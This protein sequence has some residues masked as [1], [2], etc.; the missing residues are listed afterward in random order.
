MDDL[1][2][3]RTR[4]NADTSTSEKDHL[5]RTR[6]GERSDSRD[7]D[8]ARSR[9]RDRSRDRDRDRGRDRGRDRHRD[10]S[11]SS[12]GSRSRSRDRRDDRRHRDRKDR[13]DDDNESKRD[14]RVSSLSSS[15]KDGGNSKDADKNKSKDKSPRKK[16]L[17]PEDY[18]S[19]ALSAAS[20]GELTVEDVAQFRYYGRYLLSFPDYLRTET[21]AKQKAILKDAARM[22]IPEK[23]FPLYAPD[24]AIY[25]QSITAPVNKFQPLVF[26]DPNT[27]PPLDPPYPYPPPAM[28]LPAPLAKALE[29]WPIPQGTALDTAD[30]VHNPALHVTEYAKAASSHDKLLQSLWKGLSDTSNDSNKIPLFVRT[31][32]NYVRYV[33][34]FRILNSKRFFEL[35]KDGEW[36]LNRYRFISSL[37]TR[38]AL[39]AISTITS[40]STEGA[41]ANEMASEGPEF[42]SS[43]KIGVQTLV[44]PHAGAALAEMQRLVV[45]GDH[46]GSGSGTEVDVSAAI[47]AAGANVPTVYVPLTSVSTDDK[48]GVQWR[49]TEVDYAREQREWASRVEACQSLLRALDDIESKGSASTQVVGDALHFLDDPMLAYWLDDIFGVQSKTATGAPVRVALAAGNV[50]VTS[51]A[52]LASRLRTVHSEAV[53]Y[54]GNW[55]VIPN[56]PTYCTKAWVASLCASAKGYLSMHLSPPDPYNEYKRTAFVRFKT[57]ALCSEYVR[58]AQGTKAPWG[59]QLALMSLSEH[60]Q[61]FSLS[62]FFARP[63][64]SPQATGSVSDP[65]PATLIGP[66]QLA[67]GPAPLRMSFSERVDRDLEA[68][69]ELAVALDRVRGLTSCFDVDSPELGLPTP[70]AKLNF[71]LDYLTRVHHYCYYSG[72]QYMNYDEILTLSGEVFTRMPFESRLARATP[73]GSVRLMLPLTTVAETTPRNTSDSMIASESH[74]DPILEWPEQ[75]A[76]A[77]IMAVEQSRLGPKAITN[78]TVPPPQPLILEFRNPVAL[79]TGA[80]A[81]SDAEAILQAAEDDF[82]KRNGAE[83]K[84]K[85]RGELRTVYQCELCK[86]PFESFDFLKAHITSKHGDELR[87]VR[88]AAYKTVYYSRYVNDPVFPTFPLSQAPPRTANA[89]RNVDVGA[90]SDEGLTTN[91]DNPFV[92]TVNAAEA[93]AKSLADT[94]ES[95][96]PKVSEGW[97]VDKDVVGDLPIPKAAADSASSPDDLLALKFSG[98]LSKVATAIASARARNALAR[99]AQTKKA[100]ISEVKSS[101]P[102]KVLPNY[103]GFL[104]RDLCSYSDMPIT[105][106]VPQLELVKLQTITGPL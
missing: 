73:P 92:A 63:E 11:R 62:L 3:K 56:I 41:G 19:V 20:I 30:A 86:K 64:S 106:D 22:G 44:H 65:L 70:I 39:Q 8:R 100:R 68:A 89:G 57:Q 40:T 49:S 51:R 47:G 27:A 48:S 80:P 60:W 45:S 103:N 7:R 87:S 98:S 59:Q 54:P 6:Q 72:R 5:K 15:G 34:A 53:P 33:R 93:V 1:G 12:S 10:R 52:L 38:R 42:G 55:I 23:D 74:S 96:V 37:T 105:A 4:T 97:T 31:W 99:T 79:P 16:Q 21:L 14:A 95:K 58:N 35:V 9:S 25:P 2:K 36:F 61:H 46:T 83:L 94:L 85:V 88:R 24:E 82:I 50:P 29:K 104:M 81:L 26:T 43:T 69:R 67:L 76:R 84:A 28:P 91:G 18:A 17:N 66:H 90:V 75:R 101:D 71:V 77:Y 13:H 102:T 32:H 78:T